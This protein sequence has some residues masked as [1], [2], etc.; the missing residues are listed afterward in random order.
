MIEIPGGKYNFSVVYHDQFIP[1]S[2][3]SDTLKINMAGFYIDRYPV[4]NL[5]YYHFVQSSGYLPADTTNYLSH[6][7]NG[8]F[9]AGEENYPVVYVS[10][11]DALAYATW[12]G[13]RLPR[14][15]EW[16]YA[17]QG[18]ELSLWPWGNAFDSTMCNTTGVIT[19]VNR[20]PNGK[21]I[22]GAEDLVGNVWQMTADV[23][24]NGCYLYQ[25]LKGGSYYK[26]D[27]SWWYVQGGPRALNEHQPM[28]IISDGFNRNATVGFRCVKD[29]D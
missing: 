2:N 3:L 27:G 13:K 26:P 16:Q 4:T 20:F 5:E 25:M 1:Y 19:P 17:A 22:F 6:W 10:P 14:E 11:S 8:K 29:R 21:S 23:Y 12:A 7:R 9:R 28:L 24:E 15:M 18:P